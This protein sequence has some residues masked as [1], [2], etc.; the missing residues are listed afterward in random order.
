MWHDVTRR[1]KAWHDVTGRDIMWHDMTRRDTPWHDVTWR[2]VTIKLTLK[3]WSCDHP[4]TFD[5][6]WR[7]MTWCDMMW[8]DVYGMT[9][10]TS[11]DMTRHAVALRDMWHYVAWGDMTWHDVTRH[12]MTCRNNRIYNK[13]LVVWP[14]CD[15]PA[16]AYK[17]RAFFSKNE[18]FGNLENFLNRKMT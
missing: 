9:W 8:H 6:T 1:D 16:T 2:V 18:C 10:L 12:D 11:H 13:A 14:F 17:F 3:R 5:V 4:A 15:F 7:H